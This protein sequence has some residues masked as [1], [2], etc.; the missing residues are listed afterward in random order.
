MQIINTMSPSGIRT[1]DAVIRRY[2][3]QT[4]VIEVAGESLGVPCAA[5]TVKLE[6]LQHFGSFGREPIMTR[7]RTPRQASVERTLIEPIRALDNERRLQVM[8]WLKEPTKHFRRQVDGD[9]EADG[10]SGLLIAEKLGISQPTVSQHM[11]VLVQC[12][13]VQAKRIKQWTFYRRDEG[14]IAEFKR[15]LRDELSPSRLDDQSNHE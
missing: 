3:R 7:T 4:P 13:L 11:R 2:L 15:V 10:V 5:V 6:S 12:G 14:Q 1:A 8:H 9:L